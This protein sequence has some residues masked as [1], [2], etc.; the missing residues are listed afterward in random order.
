MLTISKEGF[1]KNVGGSIIL[2][3]KGIYLEDGKF[4]TNVSFIV[5]L[6]SFMNTLLKK[7]FGEMRSCIFV[8]YKLLNMSVGYITFCFDIL[9]LMSYF[10]HLYYI[11]FLTGEFYFIIECTCDCLQKEDVKYATNVGHRVLN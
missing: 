10:K 1:L 11:F 3:G 9:Y 2:L 5:T 6:W 7:L 4:M 8:L